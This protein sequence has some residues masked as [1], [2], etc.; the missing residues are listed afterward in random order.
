[1]KLLSEFMALPEPCRA[2]RVEEWQARINNDLE[3]REKKMIFRG[4]ELLL[5]HKENKQQIL[6][7]GL[8]GA[9]ARDDF[10]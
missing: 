4:T 5:C 1:M 10:N 9:S 8:V 3:R 7:Q 6:D 2:L